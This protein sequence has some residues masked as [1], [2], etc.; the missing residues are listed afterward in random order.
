MKSL[1]DF[2]L[3]YW[4]TPT[5]FFNS[6]ISVIL[7]LPDIISEQLDSSL[8]SGIV[9]AKQLCLGILIYKLQ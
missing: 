2:C 1:M 3:L 4:P 8:K 6:Q 5:I 9:L 7:G